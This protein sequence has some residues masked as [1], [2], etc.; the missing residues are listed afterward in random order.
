MNDNQFTSD[1]V[2]DSF[3][4]QNVS[5][6]IQFS[7]DL[8]K[9]ED[10]IVLTE[11]AKAGFINPTIT[12][13]KK[14]D[15]YFPKAEKA[16]FYD[17]LIRHKKVD[18]D[19]L[20]FMIG[21]IE[22]KN[23]LSLL[24]KFELYSPKTN[25]SVCASIIANRIESMDEY[26]EI[27]NSISKLSTASKL[28][29][30]KRFLY[31]LKLPEN[32]TYREYRHFYHIFTPQTIYNFTAK[33]VNSLL[34]EMQDIE[35]KNHQG[36][37]FLFA[38][39]SDLL[40]F[41]LQECIDE[42]GNPTSNFENEKEIPLSN[43]IYTRFDFSE[44]L[45]EISIDDLIKYNNPKDKEGVTLA[46]ILAMNGYEFSIED[47]NR[48]GNPTDSHKNTIYHNMIKTASHSS[49]SSRTLRSLK[50]V[51]MES[52][53]MLDWRGN[54]PIFYAMSFGNHKLEW[55]EDDFRKIDEAGN[56]QYQDGKSVLHLMVRNNVCIPYLLFQKYK[57]IKQNDGMS[58]S[59]YMEKHRQIVEQK[60]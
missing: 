35:I 44:L 14:I 10:F 45:P 5:D 12:V 29:L 47:V 34:S 31:F 11:L 43:Y 2:N 38:I 7:I 58:L 53:L 60:R 36:F 51:M 50:N 4:I 57:D 41:T 9:I 26:L 21:T 18:L 20:E 22:I 32:E 59:D 3:I 6:A 42:F 28:V 1:T 54:A 48:L 17:N 55:T 30:W 46:H 40:R 56:P 15:K 23:G 8:S 27:I 39:Q 49:Y 37:P 52:L 33:D 16:D 19:S 24:H 13:L 25:T